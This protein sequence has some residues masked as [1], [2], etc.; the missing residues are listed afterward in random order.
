MPQDIAD[1]VEERIIEREL[2]LQNRLY[3]RENPPGIPETGNQTP[4]TQPRRH[5]PNKRQR[6]QAR[7][8]YHRVHCKVCSHPERDAIEEGFLMWQRPS[9]LAREF[10]LNHRKAIYAH[11]NALG[12]FEKRARAMRFV[13][14]KIM[15]E[16][17]LNAPSADS[18]I[19]AVRAYSC[20]DENGH[21]HEPAKRLIV[22]HQKVVAEELPAKTKPGPKKLFGTP[23]E[24]KVG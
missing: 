21:W 6:H 2:N 15:E 23:D 7:L 5:R 8:N 19:R 17:T 1:P 13:L 4:N 9:E 16:S 20:L 24:Q 18:L 11:A 12:L 3:P 22:T 14:E 10:Q